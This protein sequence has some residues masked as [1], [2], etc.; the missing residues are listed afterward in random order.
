VGHDTRDIAGVAH[1]L[2]RYS[3]L[4]PKMPKSPAARVHPP[5]LRD[6]VTGPGRLLAGV[7]PVAGRPY[8]RQA[9]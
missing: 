8:Q 5:P 4:V 1:P 2:Q 9:C 3:E 7:S 6:A